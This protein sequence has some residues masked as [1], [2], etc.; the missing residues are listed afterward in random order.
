MLVIRKGLVVLARVFYV[1]IYIYIKLTLIQN[2]QGTETH[3]YHK[4]SRSS[5]AY[6]NYAPKSA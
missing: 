2:T 6:I 5:H 4:I 3:R 1:Y